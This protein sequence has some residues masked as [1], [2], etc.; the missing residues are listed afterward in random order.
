[1]INKMK[2]STAKIKFRGFDFVLVHFLRISFSSLFIAYIILVVVEILIMRFDPQ[3]D[4][5]EQ[6]NKFGQ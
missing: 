6:I 3:H 1:M 2:E 5:C 4:K